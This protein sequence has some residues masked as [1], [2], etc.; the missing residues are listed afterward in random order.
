M[1]DRIRDAIAGVGRE[2][3]DLTRV[4][5]QLATSNAATAAAVTEMRQDARALRGEVTDLKLWRAGARVQIGALLALLAAFSTILVKDFIAA[6]LAP[7]PPPISQ[8]L[9]DEA[10]PRPAPTGR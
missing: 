6:V 7:P 8:P 2:L 5:D 4:V 3:A 1:P 10:P 9:R